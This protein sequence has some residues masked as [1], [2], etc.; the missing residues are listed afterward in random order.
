[1]SNKILIAYST[2]A[3][4]TASVAQAIGE[5]LAANGAGVDVLPVKAVEDVRAYRAV[6]LGSAVRFGQ[7]LPEAVKFVEKNQD[8][9]K[10]LP[11]AFFTMH[12]MNLGDDEVSRKNRLLYLDPVRKL[13]V[14][15]K[16]AFFA[17]V[18]D[19]SK[20]SFIDSLIGKMVKSPEGDF[21][22]WQAIR[23]WAQ[24]LAQDGFAAA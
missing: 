2:K 24:D 17:G 18:G 19:L 12:L 14:P 1:M 22:D 4:S 5:T 3:G 23:G 9:L 7:W 6:V 15:G 16:E 8:A 20:V 10:R 21:R 13:V 11:T